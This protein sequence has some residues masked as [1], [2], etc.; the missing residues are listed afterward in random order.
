MQEEE[1]GQKDQQK[2]EIPRKPTERLPGMG[3][4]FKDLYHR[5]R[6]KTTDKGNPDYGVEIGSDP[7]AV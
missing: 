4:D 7:R 1:K 2:P 6:G 5:G 3:S